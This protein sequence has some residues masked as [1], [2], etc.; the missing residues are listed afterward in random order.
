[1]EKQGP[2]KWARFEKDGNI[3]F[4]RVE[5]DH[6]RVSQGTVFDNADL[7]ETVVALSDLKLLPPSL[8]TKV[9]CVAHNYRG[10]IEQIGEPFPEEPILFL[11][12]PS[13]LLLDKINFL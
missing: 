10:L 4:G 5:G 7:T 13:C 2:L 1:M 12:P 8:P 6:V 11:K 9:V 3:L